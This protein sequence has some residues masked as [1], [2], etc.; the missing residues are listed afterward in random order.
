[1]DS[2]TLQEAALKLRD[3]RIGSVELTKYYLAKIAKSRLNAFVTV[4]EK[5][6]LAAARAA[7]QEIA[8]GRHSFLTGIPLAIKDVIS[9]C[10]LRTT[11]SSKILDNYVPPFDATVIKKLKAQHAV[12]L[13]KTNLDEF[14]MGSSTENSAYGPT[15][16]P[17]DET[18]VPGGSSGG[19]AAAVAGDLCAAALGSDTGGSIRQPAGL[20][21]IFGFKPTYGRVSR[22]GLLAMASSLDQIGPL[23]KT[24]LDSK[25][26]FE[27]IS[28]YDQLDA[29]ST[30]NEL[31][32]SV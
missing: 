6:A 2:L 31:P 9:T 32:K 3:K 27:A 21:G 20:C 11:A 1:M 13:G 19:S 29:T 10:G 28:G 15:L 17:A 26:L 22:Y 12:I 25:I 30:K 5:D 14:A 4:N 8:H 7:D 23:T 18:R 24:A 16:N